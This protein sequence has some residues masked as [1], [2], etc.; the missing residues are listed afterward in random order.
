[1]GERKQ[2]KE[3]A[4]KGPSIGTELDEPRLDASKSSAEGSSEV[5]ASG[6]D[7]LLVECAVCERQFAWHELSIN[8]GV[9]ADCSAVAPKHEHIEELGGDLTVECIHCGSSSEW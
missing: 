6:I 1:M 4:H 9:C 7:A 3:L 5:P 8:D 2:N